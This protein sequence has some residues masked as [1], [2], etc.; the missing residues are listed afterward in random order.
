MFKPKYPIPDVYTP[1]THA[2]APATRQE[3]APAT[4]P[5]AA[6][7]ALELVRSKP[8]A[9][10]AGVVVTGA[11]LTSMFLAIAIT[12]GSLAV[13]AVVLRSLMNNQR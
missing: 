8:L 7:T 13:L 9:V 5:A 3:S 10:V 12:A 2:A 11:V 1:P 6:S 4:R